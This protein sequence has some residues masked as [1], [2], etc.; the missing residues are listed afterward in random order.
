[1]TGGA[2]LTGRGVAAI[3]VAA[4]AVV[5][6]ANLALAWLA[7]GTFPGTETANSYVASQRYDAERAAQTALG[8]RAAAGFAAGVLTLEL[9]DAQGRPAPVAAL[10]ATLGRP[11]HGRDDLTL[12]L[13]REAG[14]FRA[15]VPLAPGLW[16]LRIEA[17]AEDG[18]AFRQRLVLRVAEAAP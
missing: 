10:A 2:P 9:T 14:R 17:R 6:A 15:E 18:A 16:H 5:L 1:M 3:A 13:R 8:W 4:F 11:T 12:R 7:I